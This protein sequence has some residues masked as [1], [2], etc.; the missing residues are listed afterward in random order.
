MR[1]IMI[2]LGGGCGQRARMLFDQ[3]ELAPKGGSLKLD[4]L[5]HMQMRAGGIRQF[6]L[7]INGGGGGDPHAQQQNQKCRPKANPS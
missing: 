2:G 5:L 7:A 1:A 3:T 6:V 4:L